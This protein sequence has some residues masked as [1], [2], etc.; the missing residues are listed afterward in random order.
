LW[1][2]IGAGLW[3]LGCAPAAEYVAWNKGLSMAE[4]FFLGVVLG[5]IGALVEALL[6]DETRSPVLE[7]IDSPP[8][9][10]A[11]RLPR[12]TATTESTEVDPSRW[13]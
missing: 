5:P 2:L 6:P 3:S 9:P 11:T 1:W 4:G 12:M 13:R 8:S 10:L 7:D